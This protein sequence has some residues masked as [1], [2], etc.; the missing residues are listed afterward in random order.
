M[1]DEEIGR[2]IAR[3]NAEAIGYEEVARRVRELLAAGEA[4]E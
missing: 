4:K 1:S 2:E 3:I